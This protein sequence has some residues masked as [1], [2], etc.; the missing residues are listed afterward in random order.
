MLSKLA[1]FQNL[2]R[3]NCVTCY[4]WQ[5]KTPNGGNVTIEKQMHLQFHSTDLLKTEHKLYYKVN[6][7]IHISKQH[8]TH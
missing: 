7:V 6:E 8:S 3:N 1:V 2:C 4:P 5:M